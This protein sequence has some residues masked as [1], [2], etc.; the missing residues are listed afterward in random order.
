[1]NAIEVDSSIDAPQ[2]GTKKGGESV[3][4][5]LMIEQIKGRL[6]STILI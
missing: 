6:R 5:F 3:N 4:V 2:Y 1:M